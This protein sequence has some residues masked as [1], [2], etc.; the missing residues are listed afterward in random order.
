MANESAE[1]RIPEVY[2]QTIGP[3]YA[4]VSRRCGG[5]R[6][7]AEDVVQETWLRAVD[8]WRRRGLPDTPAAWLTSVAH[9]LLVSHYRRQKPLPLG[10]MTSD[11]VLAVVDDGLATESIEIE[12]LI[13]WGLAQLPERQS[14]LLE[15]FHFDERP[16]ARIA[17]E[18]RMSERAVEGRLRRARQKLRRLIERALTRTPR[19]SA[20]SEPRE[21]SEPAKR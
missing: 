13:H 1:Q 2:R 3:L 12:R 14:R 11:A 18:F 21:R 7:L 15:A 6:P 4:Y 9:N 17:A 19:A 10:S 8:V 16:V 5:D 20:A